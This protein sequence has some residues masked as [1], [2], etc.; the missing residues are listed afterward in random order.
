MTSLAICIPT[1]RRNAELEELIAVLQ[2]QAAP[3]D[4]DVSVRILVIDNNPDGR[5]KAVTDVWQTRAAVYPVSYVHETAPGVAHVRNRALAETAAAAEDF[6]AFIDDDEL[7]ADSW[8][9]TLWRRRV[10]SGAAVVFGNVE[11]LYETAP[12]AWMGEGDFHSKPVL[13]DGPRD[14][15][16]GTDNCLMD[17]AVV[18]RHGLCFDTALS[19]VGGEDTLFF[20]ALLRHGETFADAAGAKTFERIPDN[21]ATLDWLLKRWRRTGLTDALMIAGRRGGG[22]MT[23]LVAGGE[24]VIRILIGGGL[25]G[26]AWLAKG[27]RM[28]AACASRL[29]TFQ[30]GRGMVDFALGRLVL[31]Y[32]RPASVPESQP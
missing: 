8:L 12:P 19:L 32:D 21:R 5:A 30:R 20:D 6:L 23:R 4:A 25:A 10:E 26:L 16:G 24:G 9:A 27:G 18:R 14:K 15:P 31:E 22:A 11:A 2:D 13:R 29:Y 17:L 3:Q 1:Y 28:S 7:P